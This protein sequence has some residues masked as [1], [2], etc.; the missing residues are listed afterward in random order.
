MKYSDRI[1]A[2]VWRLMGFA[3]ALI[4]GAVMVV[5]VWVSRAEG[6]V[7]TSEH[8][9]QY[10]D[11]IDRGEEPSHRTRWSNH[12]TSADGWSS[13]CWYR[14]DCDHDDIKGWGSYLGHETELAVTWSCSDGVFSKRYSTTYKVSHSGAH[15]R[16]DF[17]VPAVPAGWSD[18]CR[19][20][21]THYP[22]TTPP[23]ST[24]TS[25]TTTRPS[26]TTTTR[27]CGDGWFWDGVRCARVQ[28]VGTPAPST[29]TTTQYQH[30]GGELVGCVCVYVAGGG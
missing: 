24:T 21:E 10:S 9:H 22:P 16:S 14:Y 15:S 27:L 4:A 13:W 12:P 29:T 8:T 23:P 17:N 11:P 7:T 6:N 26:T 2:D 28:T 3:L 25:T 18:P 5:V 19:W 20:T 30:M 1:W